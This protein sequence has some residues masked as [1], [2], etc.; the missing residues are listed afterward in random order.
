MDRQ[1]IKKKLYIFALILAGIMDLILLLL[2]FLINWILKTWNGLTVDE[3][4]FHLSA[5]LEGTNSE[6]ILEAVL[7]CVIP[8]VI[9]FIG[10][11]VILKYNNKIIANKIIL[12]ASGVLTVAFFAF[13]V[14]RFWTRLDLGEYIT[15]QST[16]S[17]FIENEY[18]NP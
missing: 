5:P 18:V 15:A 1:D 10:L 14:A 9:I 13:S 7:T 6:M 11:F 2:S 3:I 17:D 16:D 12:T 8:T 4:I